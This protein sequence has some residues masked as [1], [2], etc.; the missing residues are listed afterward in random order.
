ML[1]LLLSAAVAAATIPNPFNSVLLTDA[2]A[3]G[4]RCLDG[5]PQRYWIAPATSQASATKFSIHFMGGGWCESI[6]SCAARAYATNCYIGSSNSSCFPPTAPGDGPPGVAFNQTMDLINI[7]SALGARWSGGLMSNDPTTNPLT[8]D[9]TRIQIAYC[10]G[11]S[12]A[13]ANMSVTMT[14]YNGVTV[15]LYF[16]GFLNIQAIFDD[17]TANYGFGQATEVIVSGDSAGGLASYWHADTIA[18]RVPNAR[19][20]AAPDS[21]FFFSDPTYPAWHDALKW[22]VTY[23]N[24]TSG[25]NQACVT[26]RAAAGQDPLECAF[27]EVV[28]PHINTPLFV[29][30]SK[31]D[32]ALDSISSGENGSN[33]TNV[34]R[35]GTMLES[36]VNATV[37][38][39]PGNAAFLTAC[40]QHCGQWAQG[41]V[42][43]Y[44]FNDFNVTIPAW[45]QSW[46]AIPALTAWYTQG[47]P[48]F[49]SQAASYPC[50][51]CCNGGQS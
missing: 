7:P 20:V 41:Q 34:M 33:T 31:Y 15:P 50:A 44:G 16:R 10:D 25:L 8:H 51:S 4:A 22:V 26:A 35:I 13:G 42:S 3:N 6:D 47:F 29:M 32:P 21:G 19:V 45:G 5:S 40:H 14:T 39:R 18:A 17:L 11:G 36:L 37:L 27:P 2:V 43:P 24:S 23:M 49:W 48:T 46:T 30:N 28:A 38:N 12:Y 1:R 9:W